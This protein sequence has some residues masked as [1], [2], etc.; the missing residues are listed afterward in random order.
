M[1]RMLIELVGK[2]PYYDYLRSVSTHEPGVLDATFSQVGCH[3]HMLLFYLSGEISV[4]EQ[5]GFTASKIKL[6]GPYWAGFAV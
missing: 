3:L 4:V 2:H 5:Y 6:H 1:E